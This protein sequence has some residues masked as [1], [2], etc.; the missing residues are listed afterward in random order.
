MLHRAAR[1]SVV[2][3]MLDHVSVVRYLS[4]LEGPLEDVDVRVVFKLH[5]KLLIDHCPCED[6]TEC[7]RRCFGF[8]L[9]CFFGSFSMYF[10]I[11]IGRSHV[12]NST[13]DSR[14]IIILIIGIWAIVS[15]IAEIS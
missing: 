10:S 6:G 9:L 11:L 2:V 13:K 3:R 15:L 5:L 12:M 1:L 14:Y 4:L 8:C 7:A